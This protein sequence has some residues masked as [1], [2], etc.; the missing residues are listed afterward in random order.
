MGATSDKKL[1][2]RLGR[3]S[4]RMPSPQALESSQGFL[5]GNT[6]MG[7]VAHS[8]EIAR[9]GNPDQS[10]VEAGGRRRPG[11]VECDPILP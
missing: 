3:L 10:T 1:Q 5:W 8:R 7:L 6:P 2:R 4:V 11:L 9:V